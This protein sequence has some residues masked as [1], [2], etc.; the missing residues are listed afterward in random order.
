MFAGK[1]H[2][3]EIGGG[4][5]NQMFQYAFYLK[6]KVHFPGT[7]ID[8]SHYEEH[9]AHNGYEL[10]KVFSVTPGYCT[11]DDLQLLK[12]IKQSIPHKIR[13]KLAGHQPSV[14]YEHTMG[15]DFKPEV[16]QVRKPTFFSGCW[17]SE[18]YFAD[19][20]ESV[21]SAFKFPEFNEEKNLSMTEYMEGRDS[22]SMHVRRGDYAGDNN[23]EG[24]CDRSYYRRCLDFVLKKAKDPLVLVFS[25]DPDWCASNLDLPSGTEIT[26]VDWNRQNNSYRDMQLM[27]QCRYNIIA[28]STFSW[29]GAWLNR[30]ALE[31]LSPNKWYNSEEKRA[32]DIIPP[33]WTLF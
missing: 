24:V 19:I 11:M 2:V 7:K 33:G 18:K 10:Q 3:V 9:P 17:L 12:D 21:R 16:L 26:I 29:W 1:N 5:G 4:L 28:N 31:I 20:S 30:D 22:I 23:Y 15:Y 14:F 6:L 32:G 8:I 25:D 13:R 27:S